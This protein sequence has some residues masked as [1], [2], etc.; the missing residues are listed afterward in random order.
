[1]RRIVCTLITTTC[2]CTSISATVIL[3]EDF[4][5]YADTAEMNT[6]WANGGTAVLAS[7]TNPIYEISSNPGQ[8]LFH[9]GTA[10]S[11]SGGNTNLYSF[12]TVNPTNENP[13]FLSGMIFDDG[14]SSNERATIGLRDNAGNNIIE[15]GHYNVDD[16]YSFRVVLFTLGDTNWFSLPD[17]PL[18]SGNI[19]ENSPTNAWNTYTATI[20]RDHIDFTFDLGS[21]GFINAAVTVNAS[22][23][24]DHGFNAVRLGG[25]S[26][27]SSP[28]LSGPIVS[29][30]NGSVR[31]DNILLQVLPEPGTLALVG[32]GGLILGRRR[33]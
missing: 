9:P 27:L 25:P 15:M 4:E 24:P 10:T 17:L 29:P 18:P 19:R 28:G 1:M 22:F 2:V 16:H 12:D 20:Y 33:R 32:I 5:S 3:D 23:N 8:S 14:T 11:G 7:T 21:D 31:F 30:N 6:V 26:D 13:L